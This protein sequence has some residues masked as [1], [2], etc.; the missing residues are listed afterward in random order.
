MTD[1]R[2]IYDKTYYKLLAAL[3]SEKMKTLLDEY[4][5]KL[6]ELGAPTPSRFFKRVKE[7]HEWS[8]AAL[9]KDIYYPQLIDEIIINKFFEHA[10]DK[11]KQGIK[12]YVYFGS[13]EPPI[14]PTHTKG[15]E[16]SKD[17]SRLRMT[18]NIYPWTIK[19]DIIRDTYLWKEVKK[20]QEELKPEW[21]VKKNKRWETLERDLII[22]ELYLKIKEQK[23]RKGAI[24]DAVLNSKEFKKLQV[25][26][27]LPQSTDEKLGSIISRCQRAFSDVNLL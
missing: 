27:E 22:Y 9:A 18:L 25:D 23:N 26:Y 24:M 19:E 1:T 11:L 6:A 21:K 15:V 20:Q 4:H 16:I 14:K 13:Q 10:D 17:L 8:A 12:W 2:I 5:M 7:Y 3:R